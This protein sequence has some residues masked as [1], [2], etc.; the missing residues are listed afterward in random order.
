MISTA[1]QQQKLNLYTESIL[2][3]HQLSPST[4]RSFYKLFHLP[5]PHLP[6]HKMEINRL[7]NINIYLSVYYLQVT[8]L[9]VF[10]QI[11]LF[12]P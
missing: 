9:S 8:V 4:N 3:F 5:H 2:I 6:F 1:S 7:N 12:C 10:T 11:I